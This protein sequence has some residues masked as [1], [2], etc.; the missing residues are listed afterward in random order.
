MTICEEYHSDLRSTLATEQEE[1]YDAPSEA[2]SYIATPIQG[3]ASGNA[4]DFDYRTIDELQSQGIYL[5]YEL[6]IA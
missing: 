2:C 3:I 4:S 1:A 5:S 6:T